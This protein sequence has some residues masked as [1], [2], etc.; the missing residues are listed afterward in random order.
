MSTKEFEAK[1]STVIESLGN[2]LFVGVKCVVCRRWIPNCVLLQCSGQ[3]Q[4]V[5]IGAGIG[6]GDCIG[7]MDDDDG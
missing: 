6:G 7:I 4:G 5:G 2:R 1:S 3:F